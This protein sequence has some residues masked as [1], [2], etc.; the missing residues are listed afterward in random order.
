[1][2]NVKEKL[3]LK[4]TE[5]A[6]NNKLNEIKDLNQAL[7]IDLYGNKCNETYCF[8]YNS[9]LLGLAAFEGKSSLVKSLLEAGANPNVASW[10][11][12]QLYM[13]IHL[14]IYGSSQHGSETSKRAPIIERLEII[15]T[16]HKHGADMDWTGNDLYSWSPLKVASYPVTSSNA[17]GVSYILGNELLRMGSTPREFYGSKGHLLDLV[18]LP[19]EEASNKYNSNKGYK[20]PESLH[21]ITETALKSFTFQY[22]KETQTLWSINQRNYEGNF[23]NKNCGKLEVVNEIYPDIFDL[24]EVAYVGDLT[25][26]DLLEF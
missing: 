8:S 19:C 12:R 2:S 7:D 9:T 24:S 16:L 18:T 14:T 21:N 22:S 11:Y 23:V 6:L 13:P 3:F 5:M 20:L 10:G 25:L 17:P 1:M 4:I 15:D 26:Q